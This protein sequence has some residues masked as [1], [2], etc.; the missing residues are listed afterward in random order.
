MELKDIVTHI[1]LYQ[2]LEGCCRWHD[3][4]SEEE[5]QRARQALIH[6]RA[7]LNLLKPESVQEMHTTAST[8]HVF[9][10]EDSWSHRYT[11]GLLEA[12]RGFMGKRYDLVCHELCDMVYFNIIDLPNVYHAV[13]ALFQQ[14]SE[15]LQS[16][17]S[18]S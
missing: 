11:R 2:I 18:D 7:E 5:N 16:C 8:Y 3:E 15:D 1:H 17:G 9:E 14:F 6:F 10:M 13:Q 4:V 12:Y